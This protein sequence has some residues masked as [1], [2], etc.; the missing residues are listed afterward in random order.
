MKL[1]IQLFADSDTE[2]SIN[3]KNSITGEKKLKEY[4]ENLKIVNAILKGMDTSKV[5]DI[6]SSASELKDIAKSTKDIEKRSKIA[7]NYGVITKFASGLKRLASSFGSLTKQSFDYLEN[8][9]L[10]QVAFQGNYT[11]AEKFINKM[12]E[13]YGLDES[14][15]T[16]TVGKFKQ[17]TNAMNLTAE[18]GEKVSTLLTQMS[19]DISS[20]YNV[21][22]DRAASVLQSS[23]AG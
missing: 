19:L 18:T 4:A 23:L 15:L 21:D 8:F 9:N 22:I 2:V 11:S 6:E 17:L 5:K 3:F 14:W 10:F 16:Q 1:N 13:M 12:S 7:F 20:L